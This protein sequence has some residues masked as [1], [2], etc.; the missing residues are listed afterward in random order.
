MTTVKFH[1]PVLA[2]ETVEGL[3]INNQARVVDAT[4]GTGGHSL[5]FLKKGAKV[6]GID[7]DGE[8][9]K[10]AEAR[11]KDACPAP[12]RKVGCFFK[13]V[14]GNFREI[15]EIAKREDFTE[16]EAI[17]FDLGTTSLQLM[18]L[19]RGFSF[20]HPNSPLDVRINPALQGLTGADLLNALREDQLRS[21]FGKVLSHFEAKKLSRAVIEARET[22]KFETVGDFL[23]VAKGLRTKP[24][25]HPATLPF[26]ALRIAV[27]SELENIREALPKAIS[28]L[29]RGGRLGVITFHSGEEKEVVG[30]FRKVSREG[31]VSLL[32]KAPIVPD[33][34]EIKANPRAR[35][36]K[37]FIIE[38]T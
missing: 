36:A 24:G 1:E 31:L 11:L 8:M 13:L 19:R 2:H 18:D 38:K 20:S 30:Y 6:L 25:L 14:Q 28:L 32:T 22:K 35:S 9:L 27:N 7:A 10:L 29:R 33:E 16:V 12:N 15:D 37:L 21:L 23:D 4:V 3:H 34:K 26:L 17:L 5:E